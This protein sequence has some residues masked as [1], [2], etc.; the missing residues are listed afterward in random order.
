MASALRVTSCF[1]NP[2]AV[3]WCSE[4]LRVRG[5][6]QGGLGRQAGAGHGSETMLLAHT[7]GKEM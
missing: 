2:A 5:A 1:F 4:L 6:P 3:C 7:I